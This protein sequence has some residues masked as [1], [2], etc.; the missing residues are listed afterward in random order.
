V[1]PLLASDAQ[2]QGPTTMGKSEIKLSDMSTQTDPQEEHTQQR[3]YLCCHAIL[4]FIFL[5]IYLS[6]NDYLFFSLKTDLAKDLDQ[7]KT[8]LNHMKTT[9][10][11]ASSQVSKTYF[12]EDLDLNNTILEE[13]SVFWSID[14]KWKLVFQ[15]DRNLVV[16]SVANGKATWSSNTWIYS[17]HVPSR[18]KFTIID[19]RASS[20]PS[21]I[22]S[23]YFTTCSGY[24]TPILEYSWRHGKNIEED[25]SPRNLEVDDGGRLFLRLRNGQKSYL[26]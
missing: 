2:T 7:I 11:S 22:F 24:C 5:F 26:R 15:T 20:I 4:G 14:K 6:A 21:F 13:N 9:N 16:Y 18:I 8:M 19:N 1:K 23:M 10:V 17:S 25:I 3:E 12:I